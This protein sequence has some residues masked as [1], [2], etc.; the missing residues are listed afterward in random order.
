MRRPE[1]PVGVNENLR[2]EHKIHVPYVHHSNV[3]NESFVVYNKR[4]QQISAR[5]DKTNASKQKGEK[6]NK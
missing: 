2:L 3:R 6:G 4:T 5:V 1:L